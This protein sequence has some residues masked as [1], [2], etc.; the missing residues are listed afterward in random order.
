MILTVCMSPSVDV[1]IELDSLNI[2]KVNVVKNKTLSFTGKAINVAIGVARLGSE[3]YA[4]GFM[5]NENGAMFESALDKE[6]V[7]FS[8][9]WK[10]G[11]VRE[12]Y[13]CIDQ[14]SMLTEIN[15]VG[16]QVASEKLIELLQMIRNFSSR[17]SVTVISGG[18]PRGVDASYY[19]ELFRA[20]DP[21][22]LKIAD[23]EGTKMFAA[24]EAGIDLV[25][26]NLEELQETLGREFRDKDDMLAGCRELLDRGAKNVLLSLGKDGAVITDGS[27]NYYCKS[28]NVAVNSTVGAGD[29]MVAAAATMM[30][31]GAPLPDIL[32][33]GVAAGTA[34]VTTFGTIS[35]TKNKYDEIYNSLLVTE[36]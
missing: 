5:Y 34:T 36:I 8:F 2:G 33:A 29:G 1:T 30:K 20:V 32:R 18:L 16:G 12:N 15:D 22:S 4:T 27:K 23:T 10:S 3:A 35:F 21:H 31:C 17:S 13:K 28:I 14:K 26:P 19:R 9:V 11:R 25:K 24:L 7:N 6:G